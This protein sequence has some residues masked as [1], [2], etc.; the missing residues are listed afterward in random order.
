MSNSNN[1]R[2]ATQEEHDAAIALMR[3]FM[4]SD[5]PKVGIFWY[6]FVNK[7]L[8]GVSKI[9]AESLSAEGD[10]IKYSQTHE[11]YWEEQH[12]RVIAK[13]NT[14][15]IYYNNDNFRKIPRG[16]VCLENGTYYVYVGCWINDSDLIDTDKLRELVIDEFDLPEE[17]TFR[18]DAQMDM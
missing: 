5:N 18:Y 15:S 8:F 10:I 11:I 4:D 2:K 14:K 1:I 13:D 7:S 16:R 12:R 6:D 3:T 9:E 17:T